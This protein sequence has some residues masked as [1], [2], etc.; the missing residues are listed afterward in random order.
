MQVADSLDVQQA[1]DRKAF[2]K[3]GLFSKEELKSFRKPNY[4]VLAIDLAGIW[5]PIFLG[6]ALFVASP[7]VLTF[8]VAYLLIGAGQ[9]GLI[10]ANHEFV[11]MT[12]LPNNKKL[13]DFLGTYLFG[14]P[15]FIPFKLNRHR[16]FIH[17]RI[18]S[19][20]DDTK[21][22]YKHDI[23]EGKLWGEVIRSLTGWEYLYHLS[24]VF[25][26]AKEEKKPEETRSGPTIVEVLPPVLITQAAIFGLFCLVN[27]LYYFLLWV[28]PCFTLA[29]LLDKI[30]S[31]MEHQP[32]VADGEE[33][34]TGFFR[35]TPGPFVRSVNSSWLERR[36]LANLNFCFHA[37]HHLW[38]QVSYQY[39]PT[40]HNKLKS[41]EVF[42]DKCFGNEKS[43]I[44]TVAKLS[45]E[46]AWSR[47]PEENISKV[48]VSSCPVCGSPYRGSKFLLSEHEYNNT[49]T[50][51]FELKECSNCTACYLDPRPATDSLDIIYPPNYYSNLAPK[52]ESFNKFSDFL[53]KKRLAP[54]TKYVNFSAE[55]KWLDVGAGTGGTLSLIKR[56][57][58]SEGLGI[59][60]SERSVEVCKAKGLSAEVCNFNDFEGEGFDFIHSSHLIEHVESPLEY[61]KKSFSLLKPGGICAFYTPNIDTWEAR[62][63]GKDWGG[64]HAPR[65]WSLLNAKSAK[66]LAKHSGFEV[67][68]ICYSTNAAFWNWSFHS[69]MISK[70]MSRNLADTLFPSDHRYTESTP[71]NIARMGMFTVVDAVNLMLQGR[72]ANMLVILKREQ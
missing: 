22:V 19:Q 14:G 27:P 39:L 53:Q 67:L 72:S 20:S 44:S 55:T 24:R 42:Q 5:L 64:M 34:S 1:P 4:L 41:K 11:H 47:E 70:G 25:K 9:H 60:F 28:Y 3:S 30:R 43:Y 63:F 50:D 35:N 51:K 66:E 49:T 16:H 8:L 7:S 29:S 38:P 36:F 48:A 57:Y 10:H 56:L 6:V 18:Y 69:L 26:K 23:R 62:A 40:I 33:Q 65:H 45:A 46:H 59:D 61:A 37:E 58:G 68:D 54:I 15:I 12:A 21:T 31:F 2:S 32:M 17:H 13:N 71:V 52:E